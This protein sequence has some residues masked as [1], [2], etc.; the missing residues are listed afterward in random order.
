VTLPTTVRSDGS[1]RTRRLAVAASLLPALLAG[2][3]V[4]S[5]ALSP[6]TI[7]GPTGDVNA[8]PSYAISGD[9]AA[10]ITWTACPT[11]SS[12]CV[13]GSGVGQV[14]TGP[15]PSGGASAGDGVYLLSA[16]QSLNGETAIAVASFTLDRT[17][18]A[19]PTNVASTSAAGASKLSFA[20]TPAEPDG[21]F[22]WEI[23]PAAGGPPADSG[24]A[25][26]ASATTGTLA[27]GSYA[28]RVRQVDAAGNAGAW[29]AP[30]TVTAGGASTPAPNPPQITSATPDPANPTPTFTWS[31][32]SAPGSS[33]FTWQITSQSNVVVGPTTTSD[34][35]AAVASPLAPGD[36]T[37]SVAEVDGAGVRSA[38]AKLAFTIAE[39]PPPPSVTGLVLTPGPGQMGLV[40]NVAS[41]P[42]IAGI[43]IVRRT[44]ATPTGPTDA[45]ATPIDLAADALSYIDS[46]LTGGATYYYA[47]YA[48]SPAGAFSAVGA[49]GSAA[50]QPLP[51][52]P[53]PVLGPPVPPPP[54][55]PPA[56]AQSITKHTPKP[57]PKPK[58]KPRKPAKSG[59]QALILNTKRLRPLAGVSVHFLQPRLRWNDRSKGVVLYNLQIFDAKGRKVHKA[60]PT[61]HSYIVPPN[62]LKPGRRYFWRVWPWFGPVRKFS[63]Q[64]LGI[65]YFQVKGPIIPQ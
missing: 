21:T 38:T 45:A 9:P 40:W 3:G 12:T 8:P 49:T 59:V 53:P 1:V 25:T 44:D 61:G 65:S 15:L 30:T 58:P 51:V 20:W 34:M 48:A 2:G 31:T 29:S 39:A 6:P 50:A 52:A 24:S 28:F 4:A 64:P 63:A 13:Q 54:T 60:F 10:T 42:G 11:G 36:Y 62:V 5:A 37:F 43:R 33:T 17:A 55:D 26:T 35:Q 18:P 22:S 56:I 41:A 23:R 19:A 14:S 27:D 7:S 47:V 57:K 16:S 32:G 46:G